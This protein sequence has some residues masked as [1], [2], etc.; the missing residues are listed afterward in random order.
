EENIEEA[1][2]YNSVFRDEECYME[3]RPS[4]NWHENRNVIKQNTLNYIWKL[5]RKIPLNV[6]VIRFN[7]NKITVVQLENENYNKRNINSIYYDEKINTKVSLKKPKNIKK[8][9]TDG[10][11]NSMIKDILH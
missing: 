6:G 9:K 3:D 2:L 11:V 5:F 8:S 7:N 4:F 1:L 10:L